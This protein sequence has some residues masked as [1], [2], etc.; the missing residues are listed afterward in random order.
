VL[1]SRLQA[2]ADLFISYLTGDNL[3][4]RFATVVKEAM[5]GSVELTVS[6]EVYDDIITAMR[7]QRIPISLII[8]FIHD[9]KKIPHIPIPV[10]SDISADAMHIYTEHRG[11]RRLH[12][13]DAYHIATAKNSSTS[14][15]TSDKY[16]I[17]NA[18]QLSVDV[19]NVRDVE[20]QTARR[21]D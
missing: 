20:P 5:A 11:P 16:M 19:I 10:T 4:P 9:M 15:L 7:S 6:S 17:R 8:E 13:F 2:E 21:N 18:K 12:Y 1:P 3:E 14:L